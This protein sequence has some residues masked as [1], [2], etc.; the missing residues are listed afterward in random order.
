METSE[1][2]KEIAT[3][4]CKFQG[5]VE[6]IKKGATNPFFKSSYATLADIL[7]VIREPLVN[8]NLS[9]VQCPVEGNG[10]TTL[11][12]HKTGEFI[13]STYTMTPTKND[14]QAHGSAMTYARR[15]TLGSIL[16]LNIQDDDDGNAGSKKAPVK[17]KIEAPVRK[18][19]NDKQY[20][21]LVAKINNGDQGVIENSEK[22]FIITGEQKRMLESAI[23]EFNKTK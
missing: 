22:Y 23:V 20:L 15:Y 5:E 19:L 3:A 2:I 16:G 6:A 8:N 17:K 9:F 10:L 18:T 14:P 12:M 13:K 4:L 11:L 21:S 7:N 1:S